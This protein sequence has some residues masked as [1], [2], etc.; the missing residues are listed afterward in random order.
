MDKPRSINKKTESALLGLCLLGMDGV[1][2]VDAVIRGAFVLLIPAV[3]IALIAIVLI[4]FCNNQI[5]LDED[6][7]RFIS[8]VSTTQYSWGEVKQIGIGT[9]RV[10]Y[11]KEADVLIVK[12]KGRKIIL[13]YTRKNMKCIR[14][15]YGE[16]DYDELGKEP[17]ER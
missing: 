17:R 11:G 4:Y 10:R 1:I 5:I 7:M 2:V 6:G 8:H 16:P 13:P 12:I 9:Q 14:T 15:Y 3:L